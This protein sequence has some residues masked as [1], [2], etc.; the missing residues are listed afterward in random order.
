M[1]NV[2]ARTRRFDMGIDFDWQVE[3]H[4]GETETV[5]EDHQVLIHRQQ[6]RQRMLLG[7]AMILS[8]VLGTLAAFA[9]RWWSINQDIRQQLEATIA[10][11]TVALRLGDQDAFLRLQEQDTQ[12]QVIQATA[13]QNY[14]NLADVWQVPG[15]I[16][17]VDIEE[18]QAT[19]VL[20]EYLHG[21]P[22]L[23]TWHYQFDEALGWVHVM[24]RDAFYGASQTL[25]TP[26][27]E[28]HFFEHDA[29]YAEALN[30]VLEP[31]QAANCQTLNCDLF[32]PYP[33]HIVRPLA[34]PTTVEV[35]FTD[36]G[37]ANG[38]YIALPR[39]GRI[40]EFP[41]EQPFGVYLVQHTIREINAMQATLFPA[42]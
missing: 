39:T 13:F 27:F 15:E 31:W 22:Y 1:A 29:A 17:S 23:V 9:I 37:V 2:I 19:V 34:G 7:A 8:A 32:A 14:G 3:H 41:D 28:Y 26:Y 25:T 42:N 35:L 40:P 21:E 24:P 10:A 18:D 20:R 11:E 36:F 30:Q 38:V 33:V 12:W 16:T 6:R 4:S 5:H